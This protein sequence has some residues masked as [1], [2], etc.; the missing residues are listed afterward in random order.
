M[1]VEDKRAGVSM[2]HILRWSF[3][4]R[5]TPDGREVVLLVSPMLH[6]RGQVGT[7]WVDT[8]AAVL[9]WRVF[10]LIVWLT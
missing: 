10:W 2:V 9:G 8:V 5:V 6:R 7:G 3:A 4:C 1:S